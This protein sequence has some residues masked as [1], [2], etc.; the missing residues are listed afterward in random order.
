MALFFAVGGF[1]AWRGSFDTSTYIALTG[2]VGSVASVIGLIALAS[3][4]LTT[5]DIREVDADLVKGLSATMQSVRDYESRASASRQEI[6]RLAQQRAEIELLVRQASLKAFTEERLRY[7]ALEL[8]KRIGSDVTLSGLLDEYKA[9]RDRVT[10][11]DGV[12]E[13][14]ER[15]DLVYEVLSKNGSHFPNKSKPEFV[16]GVLGNSVD[17]GP[18]L[19]AMSRA[20]TIYV[21]TISR[22]L[23]R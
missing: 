5:K 3:P 19:Y 12:I 2:L 1:L 9:A 20:A 13:R 11:I 16:I 21:R 22:I 8:E 6:D 10:E 23:T 17:V 18:W 14:S 7:I 15:A 4:R